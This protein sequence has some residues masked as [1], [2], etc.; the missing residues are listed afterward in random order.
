VAA[1][2]NLNEN[3]SKIVPRNKR[4]GNQV[5]LEYIGTDGK[6]T[7]VEGVLSRPSLLSELSASEHNRMEPAEGEKTSLE[8]IL[9]GTAFDSLVRKVSPASENVGLDISRS[10]VCDLNGTLHK[11]LGHILHCGNRRRLS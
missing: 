6:I 8:I 2:H 5:G 11:G 7:G 3:V 9:L 4:I 10:L 1:I